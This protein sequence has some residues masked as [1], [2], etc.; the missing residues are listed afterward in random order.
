[1]KQPCPLCGAPI[2]Q[3]PGAPQLAEH[4]CARHHWWINGCPCGA[5]DPFSA[6]DNNRISHREPIHVFIARHIKDIPDLVLHVA[7]AELLRA[8]RERRDQS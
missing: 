2:S 7:E 8:A 3:F 4:L 5:G 6:E 1:M